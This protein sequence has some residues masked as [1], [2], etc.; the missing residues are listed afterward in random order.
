MHACCMNMFEVKGC[1]EGAGTG[2]GPQ[3]HVSGCAYTGVSLCQPWSLLLTGL[4]TD[5][6]GRAGLQ[7]TRF[8]ALEWGRADALSGRP[9]IGTACGRLG[10]AQPLHPPS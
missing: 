10:K 7:R 8:S 9:N 6:D 5:R 3:Q 1:W 4:I 2:P